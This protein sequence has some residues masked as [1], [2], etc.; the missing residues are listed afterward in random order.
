M[1]SCIAMV[2]WQPNKIKGVMKADIGGKIKH[3][4]MNFRIKFQSTGALGVQNLNLNDNEFTYK[5]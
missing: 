2:R 5:I 4:S 3:Q 1:N